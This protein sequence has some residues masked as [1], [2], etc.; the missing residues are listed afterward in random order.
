MQSALELRHLRTLIA[1]RDCGSLSRAAE[2]LCLT[3][4]A[5][6][7]QIRQLESIYGVP[8]F[9]RKSMPPR[10]TAVGSRLLKLADAILPQIM[11]TERDLARLAAGTAGRLR[12]AVEC[13][14]CFDWLIPAMDAFR[15]RWP[16][17]ELDIVSGFHS[18]PV[19]LIH[20]G[21]ADFALVSEVDPEANDIH[22]L[23]LFGYEIVAVM[24][25]GHPLAEARWLEAADFADQTLITYPVPDAMLDIVRRVLAPAGI[26]PKRRTT[27]LTIVL[28]Q[29]V[30]SGRGIAALP[31]WAVQSY[32]ERGYVQSR[33]I[34]REGLHAR[35][36]GA[37]LATFSR[38][39][40]LA[41]FI[42]LVREKCFLVLPG[43][44]LL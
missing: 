12:I 27:E 13:H 23:P 40:Y 35:L 2:L 4:S 29:L 38:T 19:A 41:D 26:R 15:E 10:F 44:T 9:E 42:A 7:H 30:A 32:L 36:Y 28:L 11:E 25:K 6:S 39:P 21:R 43:I 20:Q 22:H 17:V 5:L 16:E 33:R 14:T 8:L 3:Q 18:D 31:L 34:G 24:A 1:L 37:C